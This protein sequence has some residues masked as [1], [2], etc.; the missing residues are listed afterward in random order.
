MGDILGGVIGG[1]GSLFGGGQPKQ[2]SYAKHSALGETYLPEGGK[3]ENDVYDL[4][5][6]PNADN[7]AFKNYLN[8]SGYKFQLSQGS[9][10]ISDNSAARGL[11]NSGSTGKA[12]TAYGENLGASYFDKY[13]SELG[14]VANRGLEAGRTIT[15]AGTPNSSNGSNAI[16]GIGSIASAIAAFPF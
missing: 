11:L 10:A 12:L 8:S 3:A 4:L 2:F 9:E 16:S 1:V 14:D 7:K 13:L 5:T 15:Q 6:N